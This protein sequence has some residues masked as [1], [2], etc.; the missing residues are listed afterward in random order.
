M[1]YG[2]TGGVVFSSPAVANGV[3]YIGSRDNNVYALNATTGSKVW[4]FSTGGWVHSSPAVV[5]GLVYVGSADGYFY[6]IICDHWDRGM[7]LHYLRI[8]ILQPDNVVNGIV[9]FGGDSKIFAINAITGTE[10]W[11][12]NTVSGGPSQ[13]GSGKWDCLYRKMKDKDLCD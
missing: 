7:A 10:V 13:S 3:V 12:F 2:L 9:Y 8:V 4:S 11:H 1:N 5:N 6:A